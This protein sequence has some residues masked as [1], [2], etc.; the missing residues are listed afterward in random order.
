M[1]LPRGSVQRKK[2]LHEALEPKKRG[3]MCFGQ[4]AG[5]TGGTRDMKKMATRAV[6]SFGS[7]A[8][9]WQWEHQCCADLE[10]DVWVHAKEKKKSEKKKWWFIKKLNIIFV[11]FFDSIP[12]WVPFDFNRVVQVINVVLVYNKSYSVNK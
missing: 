10:D 4:D 2:G 1:L 6:R 7:L 5:G 11:I 8:G 3:S 12:H 9:W